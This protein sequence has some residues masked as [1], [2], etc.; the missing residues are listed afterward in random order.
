MM[1]VPK[2]LQQQIQLHL[3]HMSPD[4]RAKQISM[5][6]ESLSDLSAAFH[7]GKLL[8]H[9]GEMQA[10]ASI[11]Y[12]CRYESMMQGRGWLFRSRRRLQLVKEYFKP[13]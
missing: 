3:F 1:Y 7:Q 12:I 10:A 13:I 9:R 2:K 11:E 8:D 6:R 5:A 4:E